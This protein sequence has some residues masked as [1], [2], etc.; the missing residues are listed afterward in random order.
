MYYVTKSK[1]VFIF[2]F[3]S[4]V[5]LYVKLFILFVRKPNVLVITLYSLD[6]GFSIKMSIMR[7]EPLEE[8][9]QNYTEDSVLAYVEN[10]Q[11]LPYILNLLG[12]A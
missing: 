4:F 11:L 2:F 3:F 8:I 5:F 9:F 7:Y 1:M 6:I 10:K 12:K